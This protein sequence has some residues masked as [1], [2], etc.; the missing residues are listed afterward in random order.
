MNNRH[1]ILI[2]A[3]ILLAGIGSY[4]ACGLD[5]A[6]S[7]DELGVVAPEPDVPPLGMLDAGA[8]E[9]VVPDT[10][11]QAGPSV[12][13]EGTQA[14]G[15]HTC[16]EGEQCCVV[17]GQCYPATCE[18]CCPGQDDVPPPGLEPIDL[19]DPDLGNPVGPAPE[20][21]VTPPPP[22]PPGSPGP[23]PMPPAPNE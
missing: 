6:E 14:C 18:D 22:P 9:L 12:A 21:G 8:D 13:G 15:M 20:P 23:G 3:S 11:P 17:D 2:V 4:A 19:E 7:G 10:D 1:L 16:R 5:V